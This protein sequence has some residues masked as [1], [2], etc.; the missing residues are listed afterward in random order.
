M[1]KFTFSLFTFMAIGSLFAQNQSITPEQNPQE[2]HRCAFNY[3]VNPTYEEWVT[4]Q[5]EKDNA[6][7]NK[8]T[9]VVYT[10][11]VVFHILHS[12]QSVGTSYNISQ[13]QVNSQITILNQD[14]S[15]TNTDFSTWVTQSS[16]VSA[17]ANCGIQFCAA[18]V[19]PTGTILAEP[20]I[21]RI[22]ISGKGWGSTPSYASPN[23]SNDPSNIIESTIK[24]AT[25]WDPTKYLN[26]W[27]LAF[28]DGTLGYAQFPTVPSSSTP[29]IGDMSGMGG[30]ANTDGVVFDYTAVGNTG[31]AAAPYNKGRTASHEIGHW[32]GLYHI[33]G[34]SNCGDDKV[35]DTPTQSNLSSTC[36][37]TSGATVASG[38]SAS[39]NPPGRMYQNYMDYTED[40]CLTMFSNGQ[41][42]RMV[43]CLQNC[44]RRTSLTTSTVCTVPTGIQESSTNITAVALF[45]NPS[46]G[47]ITV[48]VD[49][50]NIS[51]FTIS[52]INTLGQ[53]VYE[54]KQIYSKDNAT[55]IDLNNQSKGVYFVRIK[56]EKGTVTK[57]LILN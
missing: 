49:A 31:T 6:F 8:K 21:D 48:K 18:K 13:A 50:E 5:I 29:T 47:E 55:K 35:S 16:F 12:G 26:I 25:S 27:I 57:R 56:T 42:A 38:C 17:A 36:P 19:S 11:P 7:A 41:K 44:T 39:P 54:N 53:V 22:N 14:Y 10:I 4:K 46:N 40:K 52:V 9:A 43:A 45:P 34:D 2:K 1:K 30:N 3:P 20:G 28:N 37:S 33:N 51:D 24:P 23:Y 32:L 15:K